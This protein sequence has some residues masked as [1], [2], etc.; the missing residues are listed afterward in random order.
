MPEWWVDSLFGVAGGLIGALLCYS[1]LAFKLF[2]LQFHVAGLQQ[3][4]LTLRNTSAV[5]KRW[6]KSEQEDAALLAMA[7]REKPQTERF[8]NDPM[9]WG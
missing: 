9:P 1:F 4:L 8:A 3:A 6:S 7:Q 2:R 5:N